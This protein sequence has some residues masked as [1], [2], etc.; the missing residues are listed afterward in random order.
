MGDYPHRLLCSHLPQGRQG[1]GLYRT[2]G[3][4]EKGSKHLRETRAKPRL[5]FGEGEKGKVGI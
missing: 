4:G 1:I 3:E 2:F 5:T